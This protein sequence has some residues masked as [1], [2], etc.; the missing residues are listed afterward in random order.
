MKIGYACL[1]VGVP[2]T[3]LRTCS[4]K[5]VGEEL[6]LELIGHNLGALKRILAYNAKNEIRM[7]RISS[8]LIPFGSSPLN[9]LAWADRFQEQF[10]QL[11]TFIKENAMR[12]SMHPGQYTVLN[13]PDVE[14][15]RR[16]VLDLEYHCLVLDRLGLGKDH[17]IILH[18]GGAYGDKRAAAQRFCDVFQRL[19]E[20]I[21]QR[22]VLENDDR[23]YSVQENVE[24]CEMLGIPAVFDNLHHM[25]NPSK[26]LASDRAW[27]ERSAATWK[28]EDGAPKIHYSQQDSAKK[29]GSHSATIEIDPFLAYIKEQVPDGIDVMLEVKDKNRSAIKCMNC[30]QPRRK[31]NALEEEWGRYK[32]VVL[33]HSQRAYLEIRALLKEKNAFP[34]LPFYHLVEDAFNTPPTIGSLENAAQHVW[35]YFK[36]QA[37]SRERSRFQKSIAELKH[38]PEKIRTVKKQLYRLAKK[39]RQEYLINSYY[40]D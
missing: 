15:V 36:D 8:D 39:Y 35:G 31:R 28:P 29:A 19:N 17:K 22:L 3:A 16:A 12:V 26:E 13:S 9:K 4:A 37:D 32:Y 18:Q 38:D 1:T 34:A 21:K 20:P 10:E 24:L 30:T 7:Y 6:L 2:D 14:V 25:V 23:L 27:I 40:F 33:E 5:N 11:G